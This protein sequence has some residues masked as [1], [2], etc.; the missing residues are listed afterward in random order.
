VIFHSKKSVICISKHFVTKNNITMADEKSLDDLIKD[1]A[2]LDA[3]IKAGD[4]AKAQASTTK[5]EIYTKENALVAEHEWNE[6]S[7]V[8]ILLSLL[9]QNKAKEGATVKVEITVEDKEGLEAFNKRFQQQVKH[10]EK[11]AKLTFDL[12]K[13]MKVPNLDIRTDL[14]RFVQ[15]VVRFDKRSQRQNA[16]NRLNGAIPKGQTLPS[17]TSSFEAL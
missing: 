4:A 8:E 2:Q 10:G 9:S 11:G 15:S 13:L 3:R 12:D 17:P 16:T 5:K 1:S 14:A 7:V 6:K